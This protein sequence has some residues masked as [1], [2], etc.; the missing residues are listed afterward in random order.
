[1]DTIDG[2][3]QKNVGQLRVIGKGTDTC[4]PAEVPIAW[5]EA[6]VTGRNGEKG[7]KGDP[8]SQGTA[9]PPAAT[10]STSPSQ[11]NN[12]ARTARRVASS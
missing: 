3:Y 8:G 12:P 11:S 5:S 1:M 7:N 4:R 2:C 9:A 10:A 6:G